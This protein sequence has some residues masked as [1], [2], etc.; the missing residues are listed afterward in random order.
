[1][2]LFDQNLAL[3]PQ[4][5]V[6]RS[7]RARALRRLAY[8]FQRNKNIHEARAAIKQ[9]IVAE[10]RVVGESRTDHYERDQLATSR[11]VLNRL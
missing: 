4:S 6:F 11:A 1:V 2:E 8:A 5:R 3:N 7:D 10:E 9:A